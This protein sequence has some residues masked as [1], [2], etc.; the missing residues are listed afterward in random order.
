MWRTRTAVTALD[1]S[2]RPVPSIRQIQT[3]GNLCW[4]HRQSYL[5]RL[6]WHAAARVGE[7]SGAL[8]PRCFRLMGSAGVV[9]DGSAATSAY[10]M[11]SLQ[12]TRVSDC[13][14]SRTSRTHGRGHFLQVRTV[15][16]TEVST[17]RNSEGARRREREGGKEGGRE[18]HGTT[19]KFRVACCRSFTIGNMRAFG[20]KLGNCC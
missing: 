7:R 1:V 11:P 6:V 20:P 13:C 18:R 17:G 8:A 3:Y 14:G 9:L 19:A 10:V 2:S 15:P 5:R 16:G 12:P 4:A